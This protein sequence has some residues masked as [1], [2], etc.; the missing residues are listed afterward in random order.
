VISKPTESEL[1][2]LAR[3]G[4]QSAFRQLVRRHESLVRSTIMGMLGDANT[5][6]DLAQEVFLRFYDKLHVFRGD[7][8]LGTYLVRIAINLT[9]NELKRRRRWGWLTLSAGEENAPLADANVDPSRFDLRQ[10]I[11]QALAQL[12][13]EFRVVVV[14]RLIDGYSVKETAEILKLPMGT[15]ASRLARGQEKLKSILKDEH[16]SD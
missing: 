11:R 15:V 10:A 2:A 12:E 8:K 6:E 14:L 9:L 1:L 3:Q 5:T 16:L 13:P 4:D 7:A